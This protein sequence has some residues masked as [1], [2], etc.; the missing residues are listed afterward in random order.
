MGHLKDMALRFGV[1]RVYLRR[2]YRGELGHWCWGWCRGRGHRPDT[3]CRRLVGLSGN[4]EGESVYFALLLLYRVSC[5][6]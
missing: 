4:G 1:G 6:W 5:G 2:G 3:A